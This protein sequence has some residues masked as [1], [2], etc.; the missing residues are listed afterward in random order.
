MLSFLLGPTGIANWLVRNKWKNIVEIRKL[1]P[2]PLL[3]MSSL[4]VGVLSNYSYP[5]VPSKLFHEF[6][7]T[8]QAVA[9]IVGQVKS[10]LYNNPIYRCVMQ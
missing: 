4:A 1:G 9:R 2:L 6:K 5:S 3:L 10:I 7:R 8:S